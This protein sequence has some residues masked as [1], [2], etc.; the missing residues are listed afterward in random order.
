MINNNV[1]DLQL[2][3]KGTYVV[4]NLVGLPRIPDD[5]SLSA[6]HHT[7]GSGFIFVAAN[8]QSRKLGLRRTCLF[9]FFPS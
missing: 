6:T 3:P 7:Y 1:C 2:L 5:S 9:I 8:I 4:V